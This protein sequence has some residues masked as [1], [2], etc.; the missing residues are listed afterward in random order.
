MKLRTLYTIPQ[1]TSFISDVVMPIIL[2]N[3]VSFDTAPMTGLY[4][5]DFPCSIS[6]CSTTSI[7]MSDGYDRPVIPPRAL[8]V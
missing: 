5:Y 1:V 8:T 2:H 6:Y 3:V 4:V 7:I